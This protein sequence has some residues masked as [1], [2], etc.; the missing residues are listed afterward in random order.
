[1]NQKKQKFLENNKNYTTEILGA[2]TWNPGEWNTNIFWLQSS[3]PF[4]L[5]KK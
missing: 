3:L 5:L 2:Q 4:I 1:M